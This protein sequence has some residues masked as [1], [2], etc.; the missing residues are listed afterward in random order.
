MSALPPLQFHDWV[1]DASFGI[2]RGCDLPPVQFTRQE[3]AVL[4]RLA[5]NPGRLI[6]RE[7]LLDVLDP[8]C[9]GLGERS[10]DFIV[11]RLRR[12]LRDSAKKPRFIAT[13]YGEG[14]VWLVAGRPVAPESPVLRVDSI[15]GLARLEHADIG[16]AAM[17]CLMNK[18]GE[19][20]QWRCAFP[21]DLCMAPGTP[22]D[23]CDARFRVEV[24]VLDDA[25]HLHVSLGISQGNIRQVVRS[26]TRHVLLSEAQ[27]RMADLAQD[28]IS[29]LWSR[30]LLEQPN[31]EAPTQLPLHLRAHEA[32]LLL[33]RSAKYWLDMEDQIVRAKQECPD[34]PRLGI[35]WAANRY[36]RVLHRCGSSEATT[37]D[38]LSEYESCIEAEVL[39][40]LEAL[41]GSPAYQLAGAMLL[42]T[43]PRQHDALAEALIERAFWNGASFASVLSVRARLCMCRGDLASSI[44]HLDRA[45]EMA[46]PTSEFHVYLLVL[47]LK[48]LIAQG[49]RES[50]CS[51]TQALF[52][53]KPGTALE[54]GLQSSDPA[55]ELGEPLRQM[56]RS[57]G[58]ERVRGLLRYYYYLVV[59]PMQSREHRMRLMLGPVVHAQRLFGAAVI[60]A[61]IAAD[62]PE[63]GRSPV[64]AQ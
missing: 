20:L 17:R 35:L 18:V 38:L 49:D 52:T 59:R 9:D 30:L 12:K 6:S 41:D 39:G 42:L 29:A 4:A 53:V 50:A 31:E 33:T 14:Y 63:L 60:A 24:S 7:R 58:L 21:A 55:A 28:L 48:A 13:R 37:T 64:V 34:D 22:M 46:A 1:I 15:Y 3:Q 23:A 61:E 26:L 5:G 44:S 62:L 57:V 47:K 32:G 36:A 27:E 10:V 19:L 2:A 43:L 11:N 25:T 54:I 51:V 56:L 45:L 40:A 8:D 16:I